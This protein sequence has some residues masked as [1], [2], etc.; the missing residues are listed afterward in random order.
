[1]L[2]EIGSLDNVDDYIHDKLA[3]KKKLWIGHRVYKE[4]PRAKY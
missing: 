2:E 1:M 3:K 4:D